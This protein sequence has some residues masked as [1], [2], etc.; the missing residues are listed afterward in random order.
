MISDLISWYFF[1]VPKNIFKGWKNFLKFGLHYFSIPFLFKTL[2]SHWHKYFWAYPR[3]FDIAKIIETFL[4]NLISRVVGAVIRSFL[5]LVGILF[6]VLIFIL[7][8]IL[9]LLWFFLP[10]ILF[11]VFI[12]GVKLLF[13]V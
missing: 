6:E 13:S 10:L 1:D 4:S 12:Y 8:L 11:F 2:F 7:G 5:I 3:G 9:I